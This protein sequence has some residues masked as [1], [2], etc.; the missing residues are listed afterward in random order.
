MKK[1]LSLILVLIISTSIF[2]VERATLNAKSE[3][4]SQ[5]A[6]VTNEEIP[7]VPEEAQVV[8][9]N[10]VQKMVSKI[11]PQ[12]VLAGENWFM[13]L[14]LCFFLGYLGI[15]RFYLGYTTI[16]IVQLLTVGVLGI[17]STIDFFLILFRVLKPKGGDYKN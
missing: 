2:A 10:F 3:N 7:I 16:G 11:I 4:E 14:L 8:K 12:K 1:V 13:A 5:G 15:H 9:Q 17:W 6:V